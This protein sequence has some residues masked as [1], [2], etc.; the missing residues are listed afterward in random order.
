M[1][2]FHINGYLETILSYLN[3]QV[4]PDPLP[5]TSP[6]CESAGEGGNLCEFTSKWVGAVRTHDSKNDRKYQ[7]GEM[8]A[9]KGE[10]ILRSVDLWIRK[11]MKSHAFLL[12]Q[13]AR[14]TLHQA[15]LHGLPFPQ[16]PPSQYLIRLKM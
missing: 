14:F 6:L 5:I 8:T 2:P 10:G 4:C 15:W 3:V 11:C 16:I 12:R 1:I 7:R 9:P 13:R